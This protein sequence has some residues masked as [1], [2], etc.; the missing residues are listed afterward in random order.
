MS[1]SGE[2]TEFQTGGS[3]TSS[4]ERHTHTIS[5]FRI[6][7]LRPERFLSILDLISYGIAQVEVQATWKGGTTNLHRPT[8]PR[9]GTVIAPPLPLRVLAWR[10]GFWPT[11]L[12]P[13]NGNGEDRVLSALCRLTRKIDLE[14]RAFSRFAGHRDET[15]ALLDD[16]V[17]G[18]KA[19]ARTASGGLRR[20]ERLE[21]V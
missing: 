13:Q 9:G 8:H 18:R 1:A 5:T 6:S 19:K 16:V 7:R 3:K 11:P 14:F 21:D 17:D 10:S 12:R 20:E 2:F 15:L 4:F